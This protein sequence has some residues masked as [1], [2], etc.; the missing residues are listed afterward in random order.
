[1]VLLTLVVAVPSTRAMAAPRRSV[2]ASF[3]PLAYVAERV[4]GTRVAVTDL[5]PAGVEPHD[6]ELSTKQVDQLLDADLVI[7][8]GHGFQPAVERATE[9]RDGPTLTV[10]DDSGDAVDPH[11][12]LDPVLMSGI[13]SDVQ[14]ALTRRDPGGRAVYR[15]NAEAL[16][17]ELA[18]LDTRYRDGLAD[19][20]RRLL[21]TSHE[22]FGHLARRYGL[23]QEGVAGISPDAEPDAERIGELADLVRREHVT[24]VFT[25]KLVSPR[26]AQVLAREAGVT[27]AVLDPLESL[28]TSAQRRGE[29]YV[30]V[31]DDNLK[32]LR[33]ALDCR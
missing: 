25:E 20:A 3:Y 30:T 18:A 24:V 5:T 14:R 27:T 29:S 32:K 17:A 1:M 26:I 15:R 11:V 19:C 4:G 28:S 6:L 33:S 2:V 10:L 7:D 13:V 21:V 12:W 8:L 22:A 16:R 23:R 9:Q 31:M